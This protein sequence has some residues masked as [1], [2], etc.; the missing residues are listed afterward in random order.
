MSI[1]TC[2]FLM[3]VTDALCVVLM[4]LL[5]ITRCGI[6]GKCPNLSLPDVWG[7]KMYN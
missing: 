7:Q 1:H 4:M 6:F 5:Y 3:P 2:S